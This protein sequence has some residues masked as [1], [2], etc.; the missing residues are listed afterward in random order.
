VQFPG[1]DD[2][3]GLL[4]STGLMLLISI[5]LWIMLFRWIKRKWHGR[6]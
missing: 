3:R 4:Y 2:A 5:P 6:G 1:R